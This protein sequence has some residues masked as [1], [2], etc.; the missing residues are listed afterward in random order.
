MQKFNHLTSVL[1]IRV[2]EVV[3]TIAVVEG[4]YDTALDLLKR[5]FG[6]NKEIKEE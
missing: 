4:N 2:N 3:N 1:K 6:D 5:K